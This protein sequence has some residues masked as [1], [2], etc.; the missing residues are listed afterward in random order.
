MFNLKQRNFEKIDNELRFG[1]YQRFSRA[2]GKTAL[3]DVTVYTKVEQTTFK[4]KI[5]SFHHYLPVV[6][7]GVDTVVLPAVGVVASEQK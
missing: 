2:V 5:F 1:V 3:M 4:S 6:E 7:L